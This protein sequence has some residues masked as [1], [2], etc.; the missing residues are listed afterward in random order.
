MAGHRFSTL[1]TSL[2]ACVVAG[3]ADLYLFTTSLPVFY[4]I[5][6]KP[7]FVPPDL[8]SFYG[9]IVVSLLLGL[10]LYSIR[11]T[12]LKHNDERLALYLFLFGLVLNVLWFLIF[13]WYRS[14]FFGLIVMIMLI[15]VLICTIYQALKS[16]VS[17]TIFLVP[18]LIVMLL[19]AYANLVIYQ[20][21]PGLPLWGA[22]F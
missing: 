2:V 12:G 13:F 17:A 10:A 19:A 20:M 4:D 22:L 3:Y 21:N 18:Y 1:I 9:I 15:T 14:V 7:G 5:L 8:F 6:P 11:N 16:A